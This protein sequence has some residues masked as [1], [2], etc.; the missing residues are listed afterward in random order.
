M[1]ISWKDVQ[2]YWPLLAAIAIAVYLVAA[3]AYKTGQRDMLLFSAE[4]AANQGKVGS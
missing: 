3:Q 4:N 2:A 1:K